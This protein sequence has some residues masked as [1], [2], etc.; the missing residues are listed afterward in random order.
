MELD[1]SATRLLARNFAVR[2]GSRHSGD[3]E[4]RDSGNHRGRVRVDEHVFQSEQSDQDLSETGKTDGARLIAC[5]GISLTPAFK[6]MHYGNDSV[7]RF[8][9]L[10]TV[11]D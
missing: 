6:P 10:L 1:Q 9:G 11:T 2:A 8:N 7:S 3:V 4:Q 5:P